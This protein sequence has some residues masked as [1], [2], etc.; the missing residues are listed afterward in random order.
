MF[1][2][3]KSQDSSQQ[4]NE[5]Q[6]AGLITCGLLFCKSGFENIFEKSVDI[7]PKTWY[8]VTK[9]ANRKAIGSPF[10]IPE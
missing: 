2:L 5:K 6:P 7:T 3:P 1:M 9:T 8:N 4:S 10:P